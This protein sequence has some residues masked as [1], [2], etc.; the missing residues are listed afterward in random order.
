MMPTEPNQT[1][2]VIGVHRAGLTINADK[3]KRFSNQKVSRRT[4]AFGKARPFRAKKR[5]SRQARRQL[6][7]GTLL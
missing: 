1:R 3:V 4:G 7:I 6:K 5:R 2:L